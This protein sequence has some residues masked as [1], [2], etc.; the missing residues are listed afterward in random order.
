MIGR[1]QQVR[2]RPVDAPAVTGQR[3]ENAMARN[4]IV[5]SQ[6]RPGTPLSQPFENR[7]LLEAAGKSGSLAGFIAEGN[8]QCLLAL[9]A[10]MAW[11]EAIPP[12]FTRRKKVGSA[13]AVRNA[14]QKRPA[15]KHRH[16]SI[17]HKEAIEPH[18]QPIH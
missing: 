14:I 7:I 1:T 5:G 2:I 10:G 13:A 16:C 4:Q 9:L 12:L 18:E 6:H 8:G 3:I 15:R 17:A 11:I